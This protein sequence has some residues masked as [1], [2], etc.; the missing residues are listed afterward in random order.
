MEEAKG[1]SAEKMEWREKRN[2]V[3]WQEKE[4]EGSTEEID[5]SENK[6]K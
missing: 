2:N 1:K 3:K 4:K 6:E 5:N